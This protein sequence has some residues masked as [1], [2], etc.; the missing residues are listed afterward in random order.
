[1]L[2]AQRIV[3][4]IPVLSKNRFVQQLKPE[5]VQRI[6]ATQ[7]AL[8]KSPSVPQPTVSGVQGADVAEPA[9]SQS[10]PVPQPSVGQVKGLLGKMLSYEAKPPKL[11][12][13]S[14]VRLLYR[15]QYVNQHSRPYKFY[16]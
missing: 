1:M 9:S 13:K 6:V 8:Y 14:L 12:S 15:A 5:L 16:R 4:S 11:R 3:S 2:I 7:P 10:P